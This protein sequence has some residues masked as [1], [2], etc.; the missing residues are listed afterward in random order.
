MKRFPETL[1]GL[2]GEVNVMK[3]CLAE[4]YTT[5]AFGSGPWIEQPAG[6]IVR[7][8]RLVRVAVLRHPD[9]H[10][11]TREVWKMDD[12]MTNVHAPAQEKRYGE[13]DLGKVVH[14]WKVS[15][16]PDFPIAEAIAEVERLEASAQ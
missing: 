6:A 14:D 12:S 7:S 10:I 3:R 5:V 15:L 1:Q 13:A 4:G 16:S 11:F 2:Y 8:Q 9:G